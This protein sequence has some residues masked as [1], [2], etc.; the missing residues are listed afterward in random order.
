MDARSDG[1]LPSTGKI[2]TKIRIN[3]FWAWKIEIKSVSTQYK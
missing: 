2:P 3:I 1:K